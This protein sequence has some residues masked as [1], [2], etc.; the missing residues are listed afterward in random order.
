MYDNEI[1][2]KNSFP[3]SISCHGSHLGFPIDN[4]LTLFRAPYKPCKCRNT[5]YWA[6]D[7]I[8]D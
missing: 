4:F 8:G 6:G 2:L 1:G 5:E 3:S 7:T